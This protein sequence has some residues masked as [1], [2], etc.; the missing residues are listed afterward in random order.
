MLTK[1]NRDTFSFSIRGKQEEMGFDGISLH[2]VSKI[3]LSDVKHNLFIVFDVE[4]VA[5]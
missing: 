5:W 4:I 3:V 2:L 1:A